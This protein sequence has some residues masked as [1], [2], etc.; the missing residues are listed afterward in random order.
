M[1]SILRNKQAVKSAIEKSSSKKEVLEVLGL[2]AA[3][4]NYSALERWC[5]T[6]GLGLP[7]FI[8]SPPGMKAFENSRV[9]IE[10]STYQNRSGLKK[11]M[12]EL[13]VENKCAECG[14][15]PEWNGKPLTLQLDHINGIHNDNR[16]ENLRILCPH[17]HSQTETFCGRSK[18]FCACG[19]KVSK[20]NGRC[21]P[22]AESQKPR[23][24]KIDWPS[25]EELIVM[26]KETSYLAV[27]RKLDVSDNA[28]RKRIKNHPVE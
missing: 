14:Q 25:T 28:V 15:G 5:E 9:F 4:G 16:L 22:C 21:K 3:G 26:V 23:K 1:S 27:S 20:L 24:T 13:G 12:F 10:N 6:H 7:K 19:T 11:R 17:C 2:R 18:R 8:P